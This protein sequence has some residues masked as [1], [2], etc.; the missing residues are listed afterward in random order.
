[1][2]AKENKIL[3]KSVFTNNMQLEESG[4]LKKDVFHD[5]FQFYIGKRELSDNY[6]L[7]WHDYFEAE[8]VLSGRGK[9]ILNGVSH[10]LKRGM[11][12]L[13]KPTDFHEIQVTEK[14]T[15]YN[16]IFP[17]TMLRPELLT[18]CFNCGNDLIIYLSAKEFSFM[19]SLYNQLIY[20]Y[21]GTD[22]YHMIYQTNLL[23]CVFITLLRKNVVSRR[24]SDHENMKPI[25]R[26]LIYI[27]GHFRENPSM[28]DAAAVADLNPH[29]FCE[30]F[31]RTTGKPFKQY[32][33][34]MKLA[35]ARKLLSCSELSVTDICYASGF[36][37]L[38]HFLREF[39][40]YFGT[41]PKQARKQ[42][43]A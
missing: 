15:L 2:N 4:L 24:L 23:E 32:L 8:L 36:S 14:V 29:Y 5:N 25:N 33:N 22:S 43:L 16:M 26:A 42:D 3:G 28:R 37:T 41:T 21:G 19:Y 10:E 7:H 30:L 31:H 11:L 9:Y 6:P 17:E 12:Y 34:E 18:R 35:Y 38:S 13:A 40:A 27:Q 1:M 20:E 39:K